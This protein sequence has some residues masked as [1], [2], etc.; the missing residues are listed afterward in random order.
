[1]Q[2]SIQYLFRWKR[3]TSQCLTIGWALI[4]RIVDK[5]TVVWQ[6]S[7]FVNVQW[8]G[9]CAYLILVSGRLNNNTATNGGKKQQHYQRQ[10]GKNIGSNVL[11]CRHDSYRIISEG[12]L[13]C[14]D[15]STVVPCYYS[16]LC[17]TV[18]HVLCLCL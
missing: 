18:F 10:H 2:N 7:E 8:C 13:A 1:M 17:H 16:C 15:N 12:R 4:V 14:S 5:K 6:N 11:L 3:P 9:K